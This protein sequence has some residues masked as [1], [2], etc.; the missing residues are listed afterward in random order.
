MTHRPSECVVARSPARL[1]G[2][3]LSGGPGALPVVIR[4]C[5]IY[6]EPRRGFLCVSVEAHRCRHCEVE[7]TSRLARKDSR[8]GSYTGLTSGRYTKAATSDGCKPRFGGA[9]SIATSLEGHRSHELKEKAPGAACRGSSEEPRYR[10]LYRERRYC[11]A[12][13]RSVG[14]VRDIGTATYL[15]KTNRKSRTGPDV[16]TDRPDFRLMSVISNEAIL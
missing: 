14:A 2:Q 1:N 16:I 4:A 12:S 9:F 6:V 8:N 13:L 5:E 11:Y 3:P 10:K 7:N 15:L